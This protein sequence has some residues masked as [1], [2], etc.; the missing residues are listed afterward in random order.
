MKVDLLPKAIVNDMDLVFMN[1][2]EIVFSCYVH[3]ILQRMS[4]QNPYG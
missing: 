4:M 3:S 1:A 2:L